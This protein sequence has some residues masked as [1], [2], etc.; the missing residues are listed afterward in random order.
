MQGSSLK[1]DRSRGLSMR[2][3]LRDDGVAELSNFAAAVVA[4]VAVSAKKRSDI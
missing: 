1:N 4:V 2:P 3:T